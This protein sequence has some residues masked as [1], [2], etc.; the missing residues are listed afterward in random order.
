MGD[1]W[2]WLFF[3]D[4]G[5]LAR[6]AAGVAIFAALAAWDICRKGK[7][8]RRWR[9][10][11][12]LLA[13]VGVALAYGL[14]NDQI[15]ATISWEYFFYNKEGYKALG[16]ETPPDMAALRIEAV[17]VGLKAT[18]TVGLL[19]GVAVLI[20]N[21]PRKDRPQLA[22]RRLYRLLWVPLAGAIVL[23]ALLG[24]AGWL[25]L[26]DRFTDLIVVGDR[27]RNSL[28]VFSIHLGGYLGSFIGA[29]AVIAGILRQRRRLKSQPVHPGRQGL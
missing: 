22:Y 7:Q 1:F 15:T 18:W 17:K 12:F 14:I 21:N 19:F 10:Y 26:L 27:P 24:L 23:A 4:A 29:V 8:A 5:L 16:V 9:E 11:L 25:G 13:A 2:Q 20:A 3:S 28:C 6:I